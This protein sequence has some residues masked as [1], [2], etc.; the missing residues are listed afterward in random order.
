MVILRIAVVT[1]DAPL[2]IGCAGDVGISPRRPEVIHKGKSIDECWSWIFLGI[3]WSFA[4][5]AN[6]AIAK[7]K[8]KNRA[9]SMRKGSRAIAEKSSPPSTAPATLKKLFAQRD[10]AKPGSKQESQ[11]VDRIMEA[12]FPNSHATR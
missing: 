1:K 11:A 4:M 9:A 10:A 8:Q 3:K 7:Q 5:I 2:A 6:V 12:M